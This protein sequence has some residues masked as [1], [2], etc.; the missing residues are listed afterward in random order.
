MR[1][2]SRT[3]RDAGLAPNGRRLNRLAADRFDRS[4]A[5]VVYPLAVELVLA[6]GLFAL[7]WIGGFWHG[8]PE[9]DLPLRQARGGDASGLGDPFLLRGAKLGLLDSGF[10]IDGTQA[11]HREVERGFRRVTHA[12]NSTRPSWRGRNAKGSRSVLVYG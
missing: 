9:K 3:D 2:R 4:L 12:K 8:V 6:L 1:E 10:P 5:I 7:G 11:F